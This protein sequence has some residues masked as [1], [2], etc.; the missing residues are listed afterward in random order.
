MFTFLGQ[1]NDPNNFM[2]NKFFIFNEESKNLKNSIF[3]QKSFL[4]ITFY[5]L[6]KSRGQI[7]LCSR[8]QPFSELRKHFLFILIVA[9]NT[10]RNFTLYNILGKS[11]KL[12]TFDEW[13]R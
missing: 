11:L 5:F 2:E 1:F 7:K 8:F 9:D 12:F 10:Q 6:I 3:L 13:E 4:E